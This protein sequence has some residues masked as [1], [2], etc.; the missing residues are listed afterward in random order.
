[1]AISKNHSTH[2]EKCRPMQ[3]ETR[4]LE[5]GV[6]ALQ[7]AELII[8]N[9]PAILFRRLADPDP[10]RRKMVYV[11]PNISRFGYCSEDFI[12]GKIMFRDIVYPEDSERTLKE[13]ESFVSR[14]IETYTQIYRIV[15][16][17]GE[18]RWIEDRT[19]VVE[20]A[21]TGARYHQGI[22][23]DVHRRK[24]AEEKLRKSE[25]KYRQIVET[26]G[27][28]FLLMDE[29]FKIV[30]LN[31]AYTKMVGCSREELIGQSPFT[32]DN[33]KYRQFWPA[34]REKT[35]NEIFREF[36]CQISSCD[37]RV[38]PVLI[39]ANTLRSDSGEI[40]GN[41][42]FITDMTEQ[43][44]A[45]SLAG[46]VQR[47]L[48][49]DKVPYVQG[50]DIA[51]HS[52]PC[53][54]VGGDYYDF[55]WD[56][57]D[58]PFTVV[59][60]DIS[61]HGVGAALLMSSARAF[62]RMRASQPG[63]ITDIVMAINLHL[64][65]DVY[66]TGRFMTLFYFTIDE[67]RNSIEWIRAGHDPALIYDPDEDRFEEL[68]GPGM[69]LG[70]DQD[71][72]YRSHRRFGLKPGLVIAS[73]TDG[74]WEGCNKNGEMF[75][76]ERFKDIIRRNSME[77]AQTILDMVFQEHVHFSWGVSPEDDITLVIVKVV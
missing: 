49:P 29:S 28:G 23:V 5:E 27:E 17:R 64:T 72:A 71:Y 38:V 36:E 51:G 68:R 47:S 6:D 8:E 9:S 42:A 54:E 13:I 31:S 69:A 14:K 45:L 16:R 21:V 62:L 66:A 41:M 53:D 46:E 18:V 50:L 11:S 77:R 24:E 26:A 39:H 1:M 2:S 20:D 73:G 55:L 43:K 35:S 30:D 4:Q 67:D 75:G 22:V 34:S 15:T 70:V 44:K 40:V 25:E 76:K 32:V 63:T 60:G 3:P 37:G 57:V 52:V 74:I 59:V 33:E 56:G 58:S 19:S 10:R 12:S 65:E 48:L 7:L 61:G